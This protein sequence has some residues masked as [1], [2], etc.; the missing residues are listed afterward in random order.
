M[1]MN[2][3]SAFYL[4]QLLLSFSQSLVAVISISAFIPRGSTFTLQKG[5]L[6]GVWDL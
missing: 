5:L 2:L 1:M 6:W 4:L 3:H